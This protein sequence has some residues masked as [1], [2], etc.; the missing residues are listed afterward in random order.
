M[1]STSTSNKFL[2]GQTTSIGALQIENLDPLRPIRTD[3]GRTLVSSNL[4]QDDVDNLPFDLANKEE[5]DFINGVAPANPE[6]GKIT[7]YSKIDNSLYMRDSTGSET[8]LNSDTANIG[9]GSVYVFGSTIGAADLTASKALKTNASK[10]LVSVD[11]AISDITNLQTELD[12][13]NTAVGNNTTNITTNTGKLVNIISATQAPDETTFS[14]IVEA[15]RIV[16]DKATAGAIQE[17]DFNTAGVNEFSIRHQNDN[18]VLKSNDGGA[19]R[20]EGATRKVFIGFDEYALPLT[21][22]TPGQALVVPPSGT[23][24]TWDANYGGVDTSGATIANQLP[25]FDSAANKLIKTSGLTVSGT[26]LQGVDSLADT[27]SN[28]FVAAPSITSTQVSVGGTVK[29]DC[30]EKSNTF[31]QETSVIA[32]AGASNL[33]VQSPLDSASLAVVTLADAETSRVKLQKT[34][35]GTSDIV[36]TSDGNQQWKISNDAAATSLQFKRG[37][38][39]NTTLTLDGGATVSSVDATADT[40]LINKGTVVSAGKRLKINNDAGTEVFSIDKA[41]AVYGS[42]ILSNSLNI[43]SFT[44]SDQTITQQAT[45]NARHIVQNDS[46]V[47][48]LAEYQMRRAS[49]NSTNSILFDT[50]D[51]VITYTVAQPIGSHNLRFTGLNPVLELEQNGVSANVLSAHASDHTLVIKKGVTSSGDRIRVL[52]DTND[53][54]FTVSKDGAVEIATGGDF[55]YTKGNFE[56]YVVDDV[57]A[58]TCTLA[59]TPYRVLFGTVVDSFSTG[60]TIDTVTNKGRVTYNGARTRVGHCGVTV[61]YTSDTNTVTVSFFLFKNGVLMPSSKVRMAYTKGADMY[62][63]TAIHAFAQMAQNDYLELYVEC[64]TAGTVISVPDFNQFGL[65]LPNVIP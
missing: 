32:S 5:L 26:T 34:D 31:T 44:S 63:S 54:S 45:T 13:T 17:I 24:L 23:D 42:Q 40:L 30:D 58:T 43:Q 16:L 6:A 4:Q 33:F 47:G 51:G 52:D 27:S 1:A 12:D 57:N 3:A 64:D 61:S 50:T 35:L 46:A 36:Y 9:D 8:K 41:G 15:D 55:L 28:T 60:F 65:M 56:V 7:V 38:G 62:Q 25:I 18:L 53:P 20:I 21:I 48:G 37:N 22:G 59:N 29:I 39:E 11:L 10:E 14:G 49:T 19:L 2:S